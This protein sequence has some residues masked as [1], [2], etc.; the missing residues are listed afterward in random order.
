MMSS[1]PVAIAPTPQGAP[2]TRDLEFILQQPDFS[3]SNQD[4]PDMSLGFNQSSTS[5]YFPLL[6]RSLRSWSN[7]NRQ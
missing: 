3:A 6:R 2:F 7:D 5:D 1:L 4:Q